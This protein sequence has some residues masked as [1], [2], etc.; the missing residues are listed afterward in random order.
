M[1][2]TWNLEHTDTIGGD[3]NYCWVRRGTI[4]VKTDTNLAA[5]RA[6]KA[7]LGWSGHPCRV[8]IYGDTIAIYPR[9]VCQVCF[10]TWP[11]GE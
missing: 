7:Y 5:V 1:A 11:D 3:A 9:G 8:E 6:A 4:A 2:Y 10:L